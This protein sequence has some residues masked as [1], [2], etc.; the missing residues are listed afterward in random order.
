MSLTIIATILKVLTMA[1]EGTL[2]INE[3]S[4]IVS[5]LE[6]ASGKPIVHMTDVELLELLSKETRTPEDLI[7]EGR[8]QVSG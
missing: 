5:G 2:L 1:K 8:N 4:K 3:I 6:T 7:Q